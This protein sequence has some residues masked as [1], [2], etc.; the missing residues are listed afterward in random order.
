V[1]TTNNE[2]EPVWRTVLGAVVG[3]LGAFG[4]VFYRARVIEHGSLRDSIAAG[5]LGAAILLAVIAGFF[6]ASRRRR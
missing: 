3:G 4:G 2:N 1:S 6:V 5:L